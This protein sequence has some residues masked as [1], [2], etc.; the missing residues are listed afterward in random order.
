M[1]GCI[2]KEKKL[3]AV[4]IIKKKEKYIIH[5]NRYFFFAVNLRRLSSLHFSLLFLPDRD[6]SN[7]RRNETKRTHNDH[8]NRAIIINRNRD[9]TRYFERSIQAKRTYVSI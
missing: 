8:C 1:L 2:L 3:K 5:K 9:W 7:H 4:I 6:D